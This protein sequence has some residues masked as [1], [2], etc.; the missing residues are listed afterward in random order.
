MRSEKPTLHSQGLCS[1]WFRS[2]RLWQTLA[3][4]LADAAV[5]V[6]A[7]YLAFVLRF[8]G[9]IPARY[10]SFF[11]WIALFALAIKIPIFAVLRM[12][13]F[14]WAYAGVVEVS[15]ALVACVFGSLALGAALFLLHDWPRL[16]GVPR[17]ILAIDF[18][19]TLLG[20]AGDSA[21]Q[22]HP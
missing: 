4:V 12:Y 18:A 7:L 19:L 13:R 2:P 8:D 9:T 16:P 22:A 20:V 6:L 17:S 5:I 3:F 10:V 15:N 1:S 21:F 14:V 11:G